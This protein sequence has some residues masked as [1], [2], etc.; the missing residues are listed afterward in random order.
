MDKHDETHHKRISQYLEDTHQKIFDSNR[1]W[2][3]EKQAKDPD[4]F[5]KLAAGQTP[6]YL[7]VF[8]PYHLLAQN[9]ATPREIRA[10]GV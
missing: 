5:K 1:A 9:S 8:T 7:Y 4:F 2:V 10:P 3:A 6:E